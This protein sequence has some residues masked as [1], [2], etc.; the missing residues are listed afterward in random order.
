MSKFIGKNLK[1][2]AEALRNGKDGLV[3][4]QF[5]VDRNGKVS[6][7]KVV[8]PLGS[9]T[10]EEAIRVVGLFPDFEPAKQNG[11]PVEYQF[12][13][14]FR[15]GIAPK[16]PASGAIQPDKDPASGSA[17]TAGSKAPVALPD[18][19]LDFSFSRDGKLI[20]MN[21]SNLRDQVTVTCGKPADCPGGNF[22][23]EKVRYY[24][25]RNSGIVGDRT[26]M[27]NTLD[28]SKLLSLYQPGDNLIVEAWGTMVPG[29][30]GQASAP[31][32]LG[33]VIPLQ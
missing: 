19:P 29:K 12:T 9:G 6:D 3:V 10:D 18:C 28:L 7:A 23:I 32:G 13:L 30:N 27:G 31:F 20:E 4:V 26:V 33:T 16:A 11:K 24:L 17:I 1:Y 5:V 14:P 2:P 15:F 8:K 25:N 21:K 22:Q